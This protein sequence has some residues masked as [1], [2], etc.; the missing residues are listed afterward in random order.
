M[1]RLAATL[2]RR[3]PRSLQLGNPGGTAAGRVRPPDRQAVVIDGTVSNT[4]RRRAVIL[5]GNPANPYSRAIRI[6]R[7]LVANGY[8]VEIAA[9]ISEGAPDLE[10]DGPLVIRRYPPSGPYARLAA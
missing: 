10:Q 1:A 7:T 6:G 8:D 5:V 4:P 2:S 9:P 3:G